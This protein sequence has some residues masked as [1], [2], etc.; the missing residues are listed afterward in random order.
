MHKNILFVLIALSLVIGSQ[1]GCKKKSDL[2]PEPRPAAQINLTRVPSPA[3]AKVFFQGL[4][5]GDE[6]SQNLMVKF[7]A[8][9]IAVEPAG[10]V[11]EGSGHFHLL[12]DV[13][14]LPPLD[15]PI[16]FT[17]Q[18]LHFGQ[19]QTTATIHLE[20]GTHTLQILLAAGNH[21]PHDPAIMSEK[22]KIVVK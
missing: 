22:I 9:G 13:E 10:E 14:T 8:E 5:N 1:A 21:V 15:Q 12:I 11:K 16:P 20:P 19:A 7:G 6:V 18:M 3:N 4:K 17:D 2:V